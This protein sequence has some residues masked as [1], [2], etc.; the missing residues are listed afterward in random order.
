M[1]LNGTVAAVAAACVVVSSACGQSVQLTTNRDN[2][3]YQNFD[4][5][6]SNGSGTGMFVGVPNNGSIY[7]ALMSFDLSSIPAGSTITGVTL[8]LNMSRTSHPASTPFSLHRVLAS[9][10]EGASNATFGGGG[11]GAEAADGDATWFY[12]FYNFANPG[13]SIAWTNPGGDFAPTAS[14]T[15]NVGGLGFYSWSS[16]GMIAD[17]QAWLDN[18]SSNFGWM[19]RGGE[20][21][22]GTSRRFDTRE[23]GVANNRPRLTITYVIPAPGAAAVLGLGA[24]GLSRRRR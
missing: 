4:V 15:T 21:E 20:S 22:N 18:P 3:L 6:L 7:R 8:R 24:L 1:S 2:T 9:W 11:L 23:N 17:V 16:A 12:R 13:A 19:L 14:A 5:A 10:G